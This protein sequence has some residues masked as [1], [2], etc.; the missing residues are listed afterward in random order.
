M[1][2]KFL[3]GAALVLSPLAQADIVIGQSVPTTG[4]VANTGRALALGASLYFSRVNATGGINGE[5][6]N[7][8]VRD[9]GYDPKRTIANTRELIDKEGAIALVSYYGTATMAEL[10]KTKL[11]DNAGI[12]LVGVHSGADV[13]RTSSSSP[14]VFHTRASY[15][16]EVERIVKLLAGNL[17][18][19]RIGVIAQQ[20]GYGQAGYNALKDTLAKYNLTLAGEAWYDRSNGDTSKAAKELAKINPEAVVLITVSKPAATF[21]KQFRTA[22]GTAQLYGLSPIQFEE[23]IQ[24]VGK[25]NAH[26]LGI[27]EVLPYPRNEQLR[28]VREFQQDAGAVLR[29]GSTPSYAVMEG[30]LSARLVV[31]ALKRAGKSP[32]RSAVYNGLTSLKHYDLGGFTIDFGDKK[33]SGSNFVELTMIS[34]TGTLTR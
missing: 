24:T 13:L 10:E 6:I 18:V 28:F 23:V 31:E 14:F 26:G 17:G 5:P 34:P 27:S 1:L 4:L 22:G 21:V 30:Y 3:L 29:D 11:L 16:Q 19:T 32:T 15:R 2:R 25:K 7:H 20:D 9:D 8:V 33:R 12:P